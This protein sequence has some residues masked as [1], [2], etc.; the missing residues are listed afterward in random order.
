[1]KLKA[2]KTVS[3]LKLVTMGNHALAYTGYMGETKPEVLKARREGIA[4]LL[5]GA[6]IEG[7]AY[8]GFCYLQSYSSDESKCDTSRREY[9]IAAEL[10]GKT[11]C[12]FSRQSVTITS[13]IAGSSSMMMILAIFSGRRLFHE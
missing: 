8:R 13:T 2:R 9:Y 11:W 3:L 6:L 7:N 10:K 1:M 5:E 4:S 12:P